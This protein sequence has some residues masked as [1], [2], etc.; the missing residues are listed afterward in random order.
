MLSSHLSD[1]FAQTVQIQVANLTGRLLFHF[2]I[3]FEFFHSFT[4]CLFK[5]LTHSILEGNIEMFERGIKFPNSCVLGL[6]CRELH[7]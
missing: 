1:K 4:N 2:V 3:A 6:F 7:H 5:S